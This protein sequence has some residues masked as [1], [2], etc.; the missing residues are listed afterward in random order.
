MSDNDV[1]IEDK[2]QVSK[3]ISEKETK[4][5]LNEIDLDSDVLEFKIEKGPLR[6]YVITEISNAVESLH[7]NTSNKEKLTILSLI[8][9]TLSIRCFNLSWPNSVVFDEVHFGGF[10]T[11]YMNGEFFLDVHPPFAKM[12]YAFVSYIAGFKGDFAFSNIGEEFPESTPYGFMRFYSAFTGVLTVLFLYL[13]LRASGVRIW[14]ALTSGLIFAVENSFVTISR[15]I[16]LDS[17]LIVCIAASGYFF[18]KYELCKPESKKAMAYL[19]A[20]GISLGLAC[21]S[22][23]VGFFTIAWI[24]LLCIWRMWFLVGDLNRSIISSARIAAMKITLLLGVPFLVYVYFF[25]VHF[26]ILRFDAEGSAFFSSEF[27]STL[28]GNNI[29]HDIVAEIGVGSVISLMHAGTKGGYLHSHAETYPTGSEQQQ[30]TLYPFVDPNNDWIV[31]LYDDPN[32][33]ISS[34]KNL[35]DRTKIRLKHLATG[36]RL[37]SHDHKPPVSEYSDWQKE[38]S[39]YGGPRFPGDAND[40]WIIEIDKAASAPGLAQE[41]VRAIE[42]KFRLR[43]AITGCLLFSHETKLPK[44]GFEQQEVTCATSGVPELTLWYIEGNDNPTLPE[45]CERINYPKL[46]FWG[47]FIESHK[48]MWAANNNLNEPHPFESLPAQWPFLFRGL[49]YWHAHHRQIYLLGN[50]IL[51]WSVSVFVVAFTVSVIIEL[52]RWQLGTS[53]LQDPDVVNFYVQGSHYLL[54]YFVH[55]V[56]SFLMTRQLFL[57]HYLPAYYFGILAFGHALELFVAYF[58]RNQKRVGYGL[59]GAFAFSCFYFFYSYS[60]I[61]YGT[62]WTE[63]LCE[64]SHWVPGWDY[65]CGIFFENY[66]AYDNYTMTKAELPV[67]T[68]TTS[69]VEGTDAA[70][71][72]VE[73]RV[74]EGEKIPN[75]RAP[76]GQQK[77]KKQRNPKQQR[78]Q[79]KPNGEQ[80]PKF[81]P[82]DENEV[83]KAMDSPNRGAAGQIAEFDSLM[84][85][86]TQKNFVDQNGNP[87]D[88]EVVRELMKSGAMIM[89]SVKVTRIGNGAAGKMPESAAFPANGMPKRQVN[90]NGNAPAEGPI[91]SDPP[92]E[93]VEAPLD[94]KASARSEAAKR[95]RLKELD[96]ILND[97]SFKDFVDQNG[98]KLSPEEVRKIMIEDDGSIASFSRMTTTGPTPAGGSRRRRDFVPDPP[99]IVNQRVKEFDKI[100]SD[101]NHH[102]F[103]DQDGNTLSPKEVKK[104][105]KE[106]GGRLVTGTP[107]SNLVSS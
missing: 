58:F 57:H 2:K 80:Q 53:I 35:T 82:L 7:S 75:N 93:Y 11:K 86:G 36:L 16:L 76:K 18:K 102:Y 106:N 83:K 84:E 51:W 63:P 28:I 88:P 13:T 95:Q 45:D 42:T 12:M 91:L 23:W 15:Y 50:A 64:K 39:G 105:M 59:V 44:W 46:S 87:L 97:G 96:R 69:L 5:V 73:R 56:P 104:L 68:G 54:G 33:E 6:P 79:R 99:S 25:F 81:P 38:V 89:S 61:I 17:P 31:E 14:V 70:S 49:G 22:K 1:V 55:Y 74:V 21:S 41:H 19:L 34:F 72:V 37:H 8:V 77:G 60:P 27:R 30:I 3:S 20:T 66:E 62:K 100:A 43:H 78:Q 4:K 9:F 90:N 94:E 10:A 85:D 92:R 29:P 47:K 32:A 67:Q 103:L 98:N 65:P 101:D 107:P 40:D 52:L 48:Q 24:G 71:E 26:N